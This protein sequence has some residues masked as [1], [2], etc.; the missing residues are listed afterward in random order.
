[1]GWRRSVDD[2]RNKSCVYDIVLLQGVATKTRLATCLASLHASKCLRS[3]TISTAAAKQHESMFIHI[4][5][6]EMSMTTKPLGGSNCSIYPGVLVT[7]RIFWGVVF[8]PNVMQNCIAQSCLDLSCSSNGSC[9]YAASA[10]NRT[11][12]S[13]SA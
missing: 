1:M 5:S 8:V 6:S 7:A 10:T 4:Y 3:S 13:L 2:Q 9:W 12:L 11:I